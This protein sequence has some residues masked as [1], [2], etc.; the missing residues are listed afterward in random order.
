MESTS[1]I[2]DYKIDKNCLFFRI[3][4]NI[5]G[6]KLIH[7][8]G[9]HS[10][11]AE[12][13]LRIETDY[14]KWTVKKKYEDF[15]KLNSKLSEIIPEIKKLFPP[16]R[17]F[18][19]KDDIIGERIKSFTKYFNYLFNNINIFLIDDLINFLSLK[20]EIV[21]LFIKKYS[22]LKIDEENKVF[23]SLK[24]AYNKMLELEDDK[25]KREIKKIDDLISILENENNYYSSIL[26][27]ELKRQISFNWD[28]PPQNTPNL[29]VIKEFLNNLSEKTEN[30]TE[31]IHTFE[32][33]YKNEKKSFRL[34]PKEIMM[35]YIG[36]EENEEIK[37]LLSKT[38]YGD[39]KKR[40]KISGDF[41]YH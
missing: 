5:I 30:M 41:K 19:S 14:A 20:R 16:K 25:N 4:A 27:Y 40:K 6:S 1:L 2:K 23:I 3:R 8:G 22:M 29:F 28:E 13:Y 32:N 34:T 15:S 24:K 18:K 9:F 36:E 26:K 10:D 21:L 33:F 17:I 12:Y 31:I 7:L 39:S 35:L 11:Y 37:E 38:S